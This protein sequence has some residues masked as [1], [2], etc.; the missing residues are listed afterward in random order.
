[1]TNKKVRELRQERK[2]AERV[3]SNAMS[4][5]REGQKQSAER[6]D[7]MRSGQLVKAAAIM[8]RVAAEREATRD[9]TVLPEEVRK[10]YETH[11]SGFAKDIDP[12]PPSDWPLTKDE[13]FAYN[14]YDL[15]QKAM[16]LLA[17]EMLR[18][19]R[20]SRDFYHHGKDALDL[21]HL[22]SAKASKELQKRK[23]AQAWRRNSETAI[24]LNACQPAPMVIRGSID[25]N[26][27]AGTST[28]SV[29]SYA[30]LLRSTP[31][32]YPGQT[33]SMLADM[34]EKDVSRGILNELADVG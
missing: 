14:Q 6:D 30:A 22:K 17:S 10:Q 11:Y 25:G 2:R 27:Q 34:W 9:L 31:D 19:E 16:G 3:V 15:M 8:L 13:W 33:D 21:D 32:L 28:N 7:T 23:Q 4:A 18:Q 5:R 12:E 24:E 20:M 1:M 29:A 26:T